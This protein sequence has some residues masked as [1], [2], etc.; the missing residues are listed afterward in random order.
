M[1]GFADVRIYPTWLG[2]RFSLVE[3]GVTM[4]PKWLSEM[5]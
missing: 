1:A 5:V 4:F 3:V 2:L